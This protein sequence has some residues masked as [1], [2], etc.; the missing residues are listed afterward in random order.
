MIHLFFSLIYIIFFSFTKSEDF[1]DYKKYKKTKVDVKIEEIAKGDFYYPWGIT[2]INENT[3]L[4]SEKAGRLLKVNIKSGVVSIIKHNIPHIKFNYGQGGLLDIHAHKDGYI[5]F[6]YSHDFNDEDS[7]GKSLKNSST[8][9]AR[10]KIHDDEI[11]GLETLLIARPK[12]KIDKHWGSRIVIKNDNL[13]VSFGERDAGMIAQDPQ[14]H[15]GSIIR[16][17]TN[18]SIP[19]DNPTFK[20]YEEWLPE[21]F[22]IGLR[23]PQGMTISPHDGKIFFSQHGPMGGDNLGIV[24]FAGNSGWKDIA[25]GGT[26]YSGRKIGSV[27]FKDIYDQ[28]LVTWIPSIGIGSID[29]YEGK[30]FP[31][32]NGDM[33]ISALKA[34]MLVRIDFEN[35]KIVNQE[36]ILKDHRKIGRIR[37]FTIDS[38]GNIYLVSDDDQSSLW[39]IHRN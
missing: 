2:F 37:D 27:P 26:E 38:E 14:K 9:V 1:I 20:G 29:F 8:A 17:K 24:N 31:E 19:K 11:I 7:N 25:W 22:Q 28:N 32:W 36:I 39:K 3:L 23:N 16:I 30:V 10:G 15:P 34:K 12:L 21:I 13:Y 33:I 5:Y 6:T 18:G 4:V 35:N